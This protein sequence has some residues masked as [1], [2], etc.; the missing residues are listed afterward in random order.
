[1]AD[2]KK[3]ETLLKYILNLENKA[4]ANTDW[5]D[6]TNKKYVCALL[7]NFFILY[8]DQKPHTGEITSNNIKMKSVTLGKGYKAWCTGAE[9]AMKSSCKIAMVLSNVATDLHYNKVTFIQRYCV[10]NWTG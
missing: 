4:L 6:S 9:E 5:F 2:E 8:F 3:L 10:N 7:S 1:M